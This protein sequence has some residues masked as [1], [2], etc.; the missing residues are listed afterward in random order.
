P[1]CTVWETHPISHPLR[2]ML[3]IIVTT[4][5]KKT[6]PQLAWGLQCPQTSMER[7]ILLHGNRR[8]GSQADGQLQRRLAQS[9]TQTPL[10]RTAERYR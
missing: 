4:S 2:S 9:L 10:L 3:L 7:L 5:W 1:I 8:R 6:V